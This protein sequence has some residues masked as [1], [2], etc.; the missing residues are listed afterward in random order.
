MWVQ[1]LPTSEKFWNW[2]W[3]NKNGVYF[4]VQ[5]VHGSYYDLEFVISNGTDQLYGQYMWGYY[6]SDDKTGYY[7]HYDDPEAR[8]EQ[9]TL[10]LEN[11]L[12]WIVKHLI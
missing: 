12:S 9:I 10:I 3:D 5:K 7:F 4:F 1:I 2:V 6:P 11:P 8:L